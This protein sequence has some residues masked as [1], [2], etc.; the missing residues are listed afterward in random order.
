MQCAA[1]TLLLLCL[2]FLSA[3]AFRLPD[4][5][6]NPLASWSDGGA[7][8]QILE[9]V[10]RATNPVDP[11][12]VPVDERIAVF[13]MDGT[14]L[15]EKPMYFQIVVS[16][17]KLR[18]QAAQDTSLALKQPWKSAVERDDQYVFDGNYTEVTLTPFIGYTQKHYLDY[19]T[20]FLDNEKHPRLNRPYKE[21]FYQPMLELMSLLAEKDFEVYIVSGSMTSFIRAVTAGVT[22]V[23]SSQMIGSRTAIQYKMEAGKPVFVRSGQYWDPINLE[24]GKPENIWDS[25]GRQPVF[26]AGNSM[27][28]FE[29]LQYTTKSDRASMAIVI[30]H[31][32]PVREYEY[33]VTEL[34]E[35]ARNYGWL[36]VSMREDFKSIFP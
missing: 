5:L 4:S 30:N 31:D 7:K 2:S 8:E 36:V 11:S 22:G 9:F 27:G 25:I 13:D 29:M 35:N 28:D 24:D 23:P 14:I 33:A 18:Q 12:Y 32:D 21:L 3:A 20:T 34:L 1:L 17:H 10:R 15:C 6:I 16:Q 26:A 19:A